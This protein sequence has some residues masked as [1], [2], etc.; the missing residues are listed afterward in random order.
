MNAFMATSRFRCSPRFIAG[1]TLQEESVSIV[2]PQHIQVHVRA[3][4]DQG[5]ISKWAVPEVRFVDS[6]DKTSVGKLDKKVLRQ[7]YG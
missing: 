5:T 2:T 7:K 6:L 4:A 1:A 3:W